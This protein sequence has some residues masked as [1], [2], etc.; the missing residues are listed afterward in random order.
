MPELLAQRALLSLSAALIQLDARQA[1]FRGIDLTRV[2]VDLVRQSLRD[3]ALLGDGL[4][5]FG[6]LGQ[7]S[8]DPLLFG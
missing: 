2:A 7:Q 3:R 5:R 8:L 4:L 1:C 6:L